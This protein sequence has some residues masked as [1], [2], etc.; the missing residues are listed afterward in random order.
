MVSDAV[1]EYHGRAELVQ[2]LY[3]LPVYTFFLLFK[4]FKTL[5]KLYFY[6]KILNYEGI[7]YYVKFDEFRLFDLGN[8]IK[9]SRKLGHESFLLL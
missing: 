1:G 8:L 7:L 9:I 6:F 3:F 2:T 4:Y 5:M